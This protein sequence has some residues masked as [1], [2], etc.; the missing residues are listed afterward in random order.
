[1]ILPH[2]EFAYGSLV[3]C[4]TKRTPFKV[5]CVQKLQYL[6][7]FVSLPK[8]AQVYEMEEMLMLLM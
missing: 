4:T 8:E 2:A 6:L 3:N 7:Y 5:D 1:M